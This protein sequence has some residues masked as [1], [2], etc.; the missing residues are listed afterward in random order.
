MKPLQ[1]SSPGS[2]GN[3]TTLIT[4]YYLKEYTNGFF[5]NRWDFYSYS[6]PPPP[7]SHPDV[8]FC[9]SVSYIDHPVILGSNLILKVNM[10]KKSF[11]W[12]ELSPQ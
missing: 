2:E 11:L 10:F 8:T 9:A 7:Q 6:L 1:A 3:Q 4:I 12:F 5:F